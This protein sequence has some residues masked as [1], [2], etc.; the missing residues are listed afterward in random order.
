[1]SLHGERCAALTHNLTQNRKIADGI[2]GANRM[3]KDM[4]SDIIRPE[5]TEN[6]CSPP[7]SAAHNPEVAGSSPA[8]ATKTP[9]IAMVSGVSSCTVAICS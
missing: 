8:A 9:E 7:L 2:S 3:E 6:I 4:F 1:K 5:S